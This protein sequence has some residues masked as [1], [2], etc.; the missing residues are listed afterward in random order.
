MTTPK[1][2]LPRG[3]PLG[4]T[5]SLLEDPDRYAVAMGVALQALGFSE[6]KAFDLA[7]TATP[8]CVALG[9]DSVVNQRDRTLRRQPF[10]LTPKPRPNSS[11]KRELRQVTVVGRA[12]TLRLKANGSHSPAE[13]LFLNR[14]ANAIF[15]AMIGRLEDAPQMLELA[16]SVGEE[17]FA[18][19]CLLLPM[20]H[21]R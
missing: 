14:I 15:L 5:R 6:R 21:N 17:D 4:K 11:R 12:S 7:T 13:A 3:R 19:Q 9:R 20:A 8:F 16:A 18:R 10:E 1:T 2:G